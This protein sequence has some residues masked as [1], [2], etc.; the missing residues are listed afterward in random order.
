VPVIHPI[1]RGMFALVV[2]TI[3]LVGSSAPPPVAALSPGSE[4]VI[5]VFRDSVADPTVATA[6][7]AREH[8]F[9]VDH[10]YRVALRGFSTTVTA[11]ARQALLQDPNVAY[12]ATDTVATLAD[13]QTGATWGLDRVDQRSRTLDGLYHYTATG[14][15]VTAYVVDTGILL[16]HTEFEGR[17]STEFNAFPDLGDECNGHGTHV[18][19]T[20][21]GKTYGVAK[22]V[23]LVSVR[24]FPCIGETPDSV[25]IWGLE[26][27][28]LDHPAD[29]PA[30]ANMSFSGP[31]NQALDDAVQNV[32]EDGISVVIAAGNGTLNDWKAVD[33]CGFSPGRVAAAMTM[34]ATTS[35]DM[36]AS[37]SNYGPC[38]DW[39]APGA[40]ITSAY[41]WQ[42]DDPATMDAIATMNGTSMAT[43]HTVG[44][45][46]LYLEKHQDAVPAVVRDALYAATTKGIV[47]SSRS[48][49]NHL[50][51]SGVD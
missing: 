11:R 16:G 48:T 17:A 4:A 6:R 27:M 50:L 49:N 36:K 5:V 2:A 24:V 35:K 41:D 20:I 13:T 19:G 14:A 12:V 39:F 45:A 38:V 30:V 22:D 44:V 23:T 25:I 37:F 51:F 10:A 8:G 21:G 29:T 43:P 7:L 40:S 15:G 28:I 47:K 46:A 34:G 33:A 1:P 26:Q 31:I 42:N 18:A 3:M 9:A 32:I